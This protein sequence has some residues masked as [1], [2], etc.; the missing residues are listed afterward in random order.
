M[1]STLLSTKN[2]PPSTCR[3]GLCMDSMRD[4][5]R[6]PD[7]KDESARPFVR[8]A[9]SHPSYHDEE[10]PA[11][12]RTPLAGPLLMSWVCCPFPAATTDVQPRSAGIDQSSHKHMGSRA[13]IPGCN[14]VATLL[15]SPSSPITTWGTF[16][17]LQSFANGLEE[18][19]QE[20][21]PYAD[22]VDE[23]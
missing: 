22:G 3:H 21:W 2:A 12:P 20:Q 14:S 19:V 5:T 16:R 8:K 6:C 9:R 15:P 10:R 23:E 13:L 18:G 11:P 17:S 1:Y 7:R 4:S